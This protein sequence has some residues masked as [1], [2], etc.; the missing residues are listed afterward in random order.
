MG[1]D[2]IKKTVVDS[3]T[4]EVIMENS[5][6][7]YDGF[8]EKGFKYRYR[9]DKITV[10]YDSIPTTLSDNAF[11][12]LY[13][14]AEIANE[15]NVLVYRVTRKSRFSSIIYKPLSKDEIK[16][17]LRFKFGINKFNNAWRELKKHCIKE[18]RYHEYLVWAINPAIICRCKQ[19]PPWL[20]EEFS[21]YLNP[22]MTN[23][24]IKKMQDLLKY[25]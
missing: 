10:F 18:V 8:N 2:L 7:Y 1:K 25:N 12:L 20:Y 23:I 21:Q 14:M 4:G 15:D 17:R 13:M 5:F 19:V 24:S 16:S 9:A 3:N 6:F 11:L 22:H